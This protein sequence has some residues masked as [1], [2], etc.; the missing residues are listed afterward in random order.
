MVK[1]GYEYQ[2]DFAKKYVGQGPAEGLAEGMAEGEAKGMAKAVLAVLSARG[3][4]VSSGGGELGVQTGD[5]VHAI[6]ARPAVA[7][8]GDVPHLLGGIPCEKRESDMGDSP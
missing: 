6:D 7:G 8:G 4:R 2:S 1:S 5:E 3:V